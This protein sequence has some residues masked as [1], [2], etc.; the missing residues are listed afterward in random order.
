MSAQEHK[1]D[2]NVLHVKSMRD[3]FYG[4]RARKNAKNLTKNH[5][6]VLK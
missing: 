5:Q 3:P 1:F 4:T 6:N 2:I